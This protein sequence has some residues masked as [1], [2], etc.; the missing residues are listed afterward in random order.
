MTHRVV[1]QRLAEA[2]LEEAYLHA[3][4]RAPQTAARWLDRFQTAL[5]SLNQRPERCPLA[6]ENRKLGI[7]L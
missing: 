4:R 1:L 2:D 6:P 7:E 3:A 5:Q